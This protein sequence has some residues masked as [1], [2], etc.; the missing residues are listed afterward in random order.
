MLADALRLDGHEIRLGYA[1][2]RAGAAE[3]GFDMTLAHWHG[4]RNG[5]V[6]AGYRRIDEAQRNM[7]AELTEIIAIEKRARKQQGEQK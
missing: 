4:W 1:A 2:G 7:A 3:P 6:D 5:A